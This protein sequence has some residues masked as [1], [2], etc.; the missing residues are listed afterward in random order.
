MKVHAW[1]HM[2]QDLRRFRGLLSHNEQGI[3]R[4]HQRAK[5]HAKRLACMRDFEKKTE[6]IL[7]QNATATSADVLAMQRDTDAKRR[8]R[9]K[10]GDTG[11]STE[12]R[13]KYLEDVVNLPE[14]QD[15]IPCL[16]SLAK[17][18][19]RKRDDFPFLSLILISRC[20]P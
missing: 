19:L 18:S 9:K 8:K 10:Q 17:E 14:I 20:V 12:Q 16:I 15:D 1:Q 7:R 5:T 13:L 3:E 2:L 11:E 4:E 6:N